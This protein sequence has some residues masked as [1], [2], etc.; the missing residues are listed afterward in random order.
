ME[1]V[2]C[3][4][5]TTTAK[6]CCMLSSK[7]EQLHKKKRCRTKC[8]GGGGPMKN[9]ARCRR[10]PAAHTRAA[11][12]PQGRGLARQQGQSI[13]RVFHPTSP[14]PNMLG[15]PNMRPNMRVLRQRSRAR[16]SCQHGQMKRAARFLRLPVHRQRTA[17]SCRRQ[18]RLQLCW[19]RRCRLSPR[20]RPRQANRASERRC[21]RKERIALDRRRRRTRALRAEAG[22]NQRRRR[23][24]LCWG[25]RKGRW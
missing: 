22:A 2:Y 20:P 25:D 6:Q 13:L 5:R 15:R 12:R 10:Q 17:A 8:R 24:R 7:E 9:A 16:Q 19:A 3:G 18:M 23:P 14:R 4:G 11:R 1:G 21:R